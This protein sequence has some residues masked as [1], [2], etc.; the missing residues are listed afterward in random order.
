MVDVYVTSAFSK[1]N[2]GGNKAGVVLNRPDLSVGQKMAIAK[3]LGYSETAFVLDSE[4]AD[5][6]L[7]YYTPTDEVPLCGHATIA[8]FATLNLLGKLDKT[9]YTIETKAGIL[10]IEVQEDGLIFMEQNCPEYYDILEANLFSKCLN[11]E[12]IDC[13]IPIQTVST[14]LKDILYPVKSIESLVDLNPDFH[15][16]S[17]LSQELGVVGVHAFTLIENSEITAICRNFAPL[18]GID[19]ESATGTANCAL[20]CYLYKHYEMRSQY[21]F[22]QGYTLGQASRI[23]V[24]IFAKEDHI[25]AVYVGGYGYLVCKKT[26]TNTVNKM[27]NKILT[28]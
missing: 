22:E 17:K 28:A 7:Q 19:E 5:F 14:G 26:I 4:V 11:T 15:E 9:H 16:M 20:A 2:Q 12:S 1:N 6:K 10:N 27:I 8:T 24:N 25:D 3:E 21:I 13:K 18:Y 23:V